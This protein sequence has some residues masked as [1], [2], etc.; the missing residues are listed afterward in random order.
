MWPPPAQAERLA[1]LA[2]D[3]V[4]RFGGLATRQETIHLTLAFLGEVP[5]VLLPVLL[6]RV[7]AVRTAGFDLCIDRL[8]YWRHNRL[9]W[10]GCVAPPDGLLAL[11]TDLR[12]AL[13]D[14]GILLDDAARRFTPHLTLVRKVPEKSVPPVLPDIEP[15]CWQGEGFVLVESQLSATGAIYRPLAKF[16]RVV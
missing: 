7:Q 10:A 4:H 3:C 2:G 16:G 14:V 15:V 11:A 9:L 13:R 8:G 6:A 5:E 1:A 12:E